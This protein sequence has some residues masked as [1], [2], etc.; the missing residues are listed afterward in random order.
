MFPQTFFFQ[1]SGL[2]GVATQLER[3]ARPAKFDSQHFRA[4]QAHA[5]PF[6]PVLELFVWPRPIFYFWPLL[7]LALAR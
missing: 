3:L 1:E 5:G 6:G 4:S 7:A 2:I